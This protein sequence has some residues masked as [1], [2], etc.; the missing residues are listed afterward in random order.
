MN[1]IAIGKNIHGEEIKIIVSNYNGITCRFYNLIDLKIPKN[2]IVVDCASNQLTELNLPKTVKW[3]VCYNNPIKEI[4]LSKKIIH[5]ELPLN[6]IV[7]NL[8]DFRYNKN[9]RIKFR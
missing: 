4:T 3:V 7:T 9:V 8:D 5:A 6:C 1:E 2:I